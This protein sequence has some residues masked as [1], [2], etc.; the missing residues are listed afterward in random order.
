MKNL[1][2]FRSGW[3]IAL[4]SLL[5]G[6]AAASTIRDDVADSEYTGFAD[7]N[8]QSVGFVYG[9]D[10][11]GSATLI[12][13]NW[14]MTAGHVG[15]ALLNTLSN[16]DRGF[17]LA[18]D[19]SVNS[20]SYDYDQVFI[21]PLFNQSQS[22]D[23]DIAL[24]HLTGAGVTNVTP[25]GLDGSAVSIGS[26]VASVGYG[27][28]GTGLTGDIITNNTLRRGFENVVDALNYGQGTGN[29]LPG[30][31]A[32]FDNPQGTANTLGFLGSSPYPLHLEGCLANGDS[33]SGMFTQVN[34]QWELAGVGSY[35]ASP[36]NEGAV[37]SFY[38]DVSGWADTY[39]DLAW[40]SNV[41]GVQ[42]VPEPAPIIALGI[43][44]LVVVRRRK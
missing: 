41:S 1:L 40:I 14:I 18:D 29:F 9:A 35:V 31:I 19:L 4:I 21:D 39:Q 13:P 38:G 25:L 10:E 12:A 24:I 28:T 42:P 44:A 16:P 3:S 8:F 22:L 11:S 32:D 26:T 5:V 34:G 17:R 43:A 33:G 7:T 37:T 36:N 23:H 20:P 15:Q 27:A 2:N 6:S 30:Y